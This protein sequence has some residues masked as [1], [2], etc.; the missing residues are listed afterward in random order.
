MASLNDLSKPVGQNPTISLQQLTEAVGTDPTSSLAKLAGAS[1]SA[2]VPGW[3]W[4]RHVKFRFLNEVHQGPTLN[5]LTQPPG[6]N[7][8][9]S[10]DKLTQ[11]QPPAGAVSRR[12]TVGEVGQWS[13]IT[14][15]TFKLLDE[16]EM[17][18]PAG[19]LW[20]LEYELTES[21]GAEANAGFIRIY[22]PS[23]PTIYK[24]RTAIEYKNLY[25]EVLT[26]YRDMPLKR[27]F[28]G[29]VENVRVHPD[30]SSWYAEIH[31]TDSGP[32]LLNERIALLLPI[33]IDGSKVIKEL[34]AQLNVEIGYFQIGKEYVYERGFA[35]DL[36]KTVW[37]QLQGVASDNQCNC[38]IFIARG[39]AWVYPRKGYE[40]MHVTVDVE[41][42]L[43][44]LPEPA[45]DIST[46]SQQPTHWTVK[47]VNWPDARPKVAYTVRTKT[48]E[49][50]GVILTQKNVC[51]RS[52]FTTEM[53][54]MELHLKDEEKQDVKMP[55]D[56]S[57]VPKM[58][59][60][61]R[62]P[63]VFS[64]FQPPK[65]NGK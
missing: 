2:G 9:I 33:P 27:I 13:T 45:Q 64:T 58:F 43:L 49:L 7:P 14:G 39:I 15:R 16:V 36:N 26:A 18:W 6:Q 32:K 56:L 28:F 48:L 35:V 20:H 57:K 29:C 34:L 51:N 4:E 50:K 60:T 63:Q 1:G 38:D 42:G 5:D 19:E 30:G 37:S 21:S 24:W 31:L 10:L 62:P 46:D 23:R 12:A 59:S 55:P 11:P 44:G 61:W 22:N 53:Q 8:T 3:A 17:Y 41:H 65:D 54:L 47:T 25:V 52:A 40:D